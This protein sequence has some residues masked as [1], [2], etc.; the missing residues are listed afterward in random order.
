[1]P[2][3]LVELFQVLMVRA[4]VVAH[5]PTRQV[6][7]EV[8]LVVVYRALVD[9]LVVAPAHHELVKPAATLVAVVQLELC[10]EPERISQTTHLKLLHT[11]SR[12]NVLSLKS[13]KL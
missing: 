9:F 1:V 4:V 10:G 11:S 5:P 13:T 7:M 6:Q 3:A 8:P 2:A 12:T